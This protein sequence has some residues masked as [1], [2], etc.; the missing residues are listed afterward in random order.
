MSKDGMVAGF[1]YLCFTLAVGEVQIVPY[2]PE[3]SP[4]GYH[5]IKR[6]N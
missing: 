5:V 3:T 6:T 4:Y 1:G 2:D